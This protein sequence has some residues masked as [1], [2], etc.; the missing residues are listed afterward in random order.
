M[1][2]NFNAGVSGVLTA[3]RVMEVIG[4]NIAN[5]NTEN[6]SRQIAHL[7]NLPPAPICDVHVGQGVRI[8]I[9]T[10]VRDDLVESRLRLGESG[11]AGSQ[12]LRE[13]TTQ[14]EEFFNDPTEGGINALLARLNNNFEELSVRP[15]DTAVQIQ[16]V[17]DAVRL[18]DR[19]QLTKRQLIE[20]SE[21]IPDEIQS[22]TIK[23]ND[24]LER[25]AETNTEILRLE[26]GGQ[27]ANDFIDRSNFLLRE[28]SKLVKVEVMEDGLRQRRVTLNGEILVRGDRASTVSVSDTRPEM[29]QIKCDGR[30]SLVTPTDGEVASL[31]KTRI[32]IIP[33][34]C[35][36]LDD[37]VRGLMRAVNGVHSE[38]MGLDGRFTELVSE[39]AVADT[40][41][42]GDATNDLL[43]D[44]EGLFIP[45][46]AGFIRVAIAN[47]NVVPQTI[48]RFEIAIEP[49][50]DTLAT[51]AAKLA[52]LP[53]LNAVADP[54]TG[55][56]TISAQDGF[57]FDFSKPT[58]LG[59]LNPADAGS[60]S[61][62]LAGEFTGEGS[63]NYT[64]TI[65]NAIPADGK[66]TAEVGHGEITAEVRDKNGAL[67]RTLSLGEGYIPGEALTVANGLAVRFGPGTVVTG[68]SLSTPVY[69]ADTDTA[70][71]FAA[72]GINSFF[73]GS[74]A[75]TIAVSKRILENPRNI[76]HA[77]SPSPGDPENAHRLS[78][79]FS[80][81]LDIPEFTRRTTIA[82][83]FQNLVE[84]VGQRS[85]TLELREE[86]QRQSVE[87]IFALRESISGVSVDEE[88]AN[89]LRFQ[90][91]FQ[92]NARHIS[93]MSQLIQILNNL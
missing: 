77:L 23:I 75:R 66:V 33:E 46:T 62:K 72:L 30:I 13:Y 7:E 39:N 61:V 80:D 76:A 85:Q 11:L 45:P 32:E 60:P 26:S 14:I 81:N 37:F 82:G 64:F 43:F 17:N 65:T 51:I 4:H 79:L 6:Y 53:G 58:E 54:A 31:L 41:N 70:D 22:R 10:S 50:K 12:K 25:I 8:Q 19:I 35:D 59:K 48:A 20:L 71:L 86:Q 18:T 73:V 52:A 36:K 63:D 87:A 3:R 57:S 44:N 68:N 38:G 47:D 15:Q 93:A 1:P 40:N 5:V 90:Q 74:D 56:L 84:A 88:M 42:D 24:L 21:M 2:I 55:K 28:L 92:A 49:T 34:L 78:A 83:T 16:L 67:L 9:V 27:P 91:M 89:L 29:L 69:S